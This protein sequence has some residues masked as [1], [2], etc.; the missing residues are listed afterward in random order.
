LFSVRH[1]LTNNFL[2]VKLPDCKVLASVDYFK[3]SDDSSKEY[4]SD[5]KSVALSSHFGEGRVLIIGAHPEAPGLQFKPFINSCI[6]WCSKT[7]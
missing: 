4:V 6:N 1:S 7:S 2:N 5:K 3:L